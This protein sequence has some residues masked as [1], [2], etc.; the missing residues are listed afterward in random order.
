MDT[1]DIQGRK[2]FGDF[3]LGEVLGSPCQNGKKTIPLK[4]NGG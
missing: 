3:L 1:D 4:K 2:L